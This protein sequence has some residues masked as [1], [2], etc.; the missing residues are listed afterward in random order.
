MLNVNLVYLPFERNKPN[1]KSGKCNAVVLLSTYST[2]LSI[3]F[4]KYLKSSDDGIILYASLSVAF[5][6]VPDNINKHKIFLI[7]GTTMLYS[8]LAVV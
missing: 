4:T 8:A 7:Q 3:A 5:A 6:F 1:I 2:T